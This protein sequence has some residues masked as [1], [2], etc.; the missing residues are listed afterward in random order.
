MSFMP[1]ARF[2]HHGYLRVVGEEGEERRLHLSPEEVAEIL[3]EDKA[4]PIGRDPK[5][6]D[7]IHRAFYSKPDDEC[8]VAVQDETNGEVI[9]LL[10]FSHHGR[11]VVDTVKVRKIAMQLMGANSCP[12]Y[13]PEKIVAGPETECVVSMKVQLEPP[14]DTKRIRLVRTPVPDGSVLQK[15]HMDEELRKKIQVEAS[16]ALNALW[17][18]A[19]VISFRMHFVSHGRASEFQRF[20]NKLEKVI[21]KE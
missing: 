20:D 17:G 3:D 6:P 12:A 14:R 5:D 9:T 18:N 13:E 15:M 10:P 8:I 1:K 19:Q 21:P 16:I 7:K 4:V 11:F 2:T